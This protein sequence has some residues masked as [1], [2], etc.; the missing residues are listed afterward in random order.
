LKK[1]TAKVF[2]DEDELIFKEQVLQKMDQN[3]E[4]V[5]PRETILDLSEPKT[6]ELAKEIE[7]AKIQY[8]E[9]RLQA[10]FEEAKEKFEITSLLKM[11]A[12]S[13]KEQYLTAAMVAR[14]A[15]KAVKRL[16]PKRKQKQLKE[17]KS[18]N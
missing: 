17:K 7:K 18:G 9:K 6:F 4:G 5:T 1:F 11:M 13:I 14:L 16:K 10:K 8:K 15:F 12:D 2:F 3:N